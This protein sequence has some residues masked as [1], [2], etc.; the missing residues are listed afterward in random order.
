[1]KTMDEVWGDGSDHECCEKCHYCI[2][3][4]DCARDGCGALSPELK[5][6][7]WTKDGNGK[8][9]PPPGHVA[10]ALSVPNDGGKRSDD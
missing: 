7:G 1:M 4:G 2:T 6:A 10:E 8:L 3:C 5:K 9:V